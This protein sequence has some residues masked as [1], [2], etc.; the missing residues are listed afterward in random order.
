MKSAEAQVKAPRPSGSDSGRK[1]DQ[2]VDGDGMA[3]PKY[4]YDSDGNKIGKYVINN[5]G[6][7]VFKRYKNKS[8][9]R[10]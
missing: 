9:G 7:R 3:W 8:S 1:S 4:K 6:E 5:E 2:I 10:D